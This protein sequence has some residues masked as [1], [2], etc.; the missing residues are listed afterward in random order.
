M[1]VDKA[2]DTLVRLGL[3]TEAE[4]EVSVDG[5]SG[6]LLRAIP[7]FEAYEI[8]KQRWNSLLN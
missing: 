2:M 1:P 6:R 7:C 4:E 3:V 8:L 5:K